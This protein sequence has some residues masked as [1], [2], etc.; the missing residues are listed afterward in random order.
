MGVV[1]RRRD[2]DQN[3]RLIEPGDLVIEVIGKDVVTYTIPKTPKARR[4]AA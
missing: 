1:T 2:V 4:S 3:G